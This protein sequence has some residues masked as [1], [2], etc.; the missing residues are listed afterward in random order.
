MGNNFVQLGPTEFIQER[1]FTNPQ[2]STADLDHLQYIADKV[3][4]LLLSEPQ[5]FDNQRFPMIIF[6][7]EEEGRYFRIT[8]AQPQALLAKHDFY[9]VGFCGTKRP[10]SDR[11]PVDS[12]DDELIG[13]FPE[14]PSLICYCTLE[15]EPGHTCNLVLFDNP[16][17]LT[18]WS[19]SAKHARAV[20]LSPD[21]YLSIRLHNALLPGGLLS[22]QPLAL[23]R[24]KYFDF[25][26]EAV[27]WGL[28][29][30]PVQ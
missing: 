5:R 23:M 14:H 1:P 18:H 19:R 27:W 15:V 22:N 26:G 3:R 30:L 29:E 10:R 7:S 9:A 4:Q 6:L 8:V 16:T 25:Q 2:I 11:G 20:E 12:I 28:R 21:Y 17:G 24:T 13:E